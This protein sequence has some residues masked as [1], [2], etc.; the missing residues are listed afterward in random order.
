MSAD[1]AIVITNES[2]TA[3]SPTQYLLKIS[4]FGFFATMGCAENSIKYFVIAENTHL[5]HEIKS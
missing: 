4:Q 1:A 5:K 3:P 2:F